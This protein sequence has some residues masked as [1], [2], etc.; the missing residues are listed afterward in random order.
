LLYPG[1]NV[2]TFGV[3]GKVVHIGI[4]ATVIEQV[5]NLVALWNRSDPEVVAREGGQEHQRG[6]KDDDAEDDENDKK[7]GNGED[8]HSH[9]SGKDKPRGAGRGAGRRG[10]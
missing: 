2:E 3:V 1:R 9:H 7:N 10:S 4:P 6:S 8:P 5:Q